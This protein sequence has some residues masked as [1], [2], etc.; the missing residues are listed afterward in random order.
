[1]LCYVTVVSCLCS[2]FT[3]VSVDSSVYRCWCHCQPTRCT[4]E[5]L[6]RYLFVMLV[7]RKAVWNRVAIVGPKIKTQ[8]KLWANIYWTIANVNVLSFII[9]DYLLCTEFDH[10]ILT[11]QIPY[12]VDL[13][14]INLFFQ[15]RCIRSSG[16]P[17]KRMWWTTFGPWA[18]SL[19]YGSRRSFSLV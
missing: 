2:V 15:I 5:C 13:D 9:L 16:G 7:S 18:S 14:K 10:Y 4:I 8:T 11:L 3:L 1:M 17:H 19:T 12:T 6:K